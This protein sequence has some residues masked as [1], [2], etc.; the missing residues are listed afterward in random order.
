MHGSRGWSFTGSLNSVGFRVRRALGVVIPPIAAV[1]LLVA[2]M[3]AS[4]LQPRIALADVCGPPLVNPIACENTKTGS[5]V[6]N[7]DITGSPDQSL[8]GFTDN[9][10]YTPG[11]TVNFKITSPA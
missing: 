9:I 2:A 8:Q 6:A 1:A 5:P 11:A 7:W 4:T 10:S 3:P